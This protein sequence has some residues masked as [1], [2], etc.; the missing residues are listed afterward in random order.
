MLVRTFRQLLRGRP[1]SPPLPASAEDLTISKIDDGVWH[2]SPI[3]PEDVVE[4][5]FE[6]RGK[7]FL[8]VLEPGELPVF[9]QVLDGIKDSAAP[10]NLVAEF[11]RRLGRNPFVEVPPPWYRRFTATRPHRAMRPGP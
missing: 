10:I 6:N 4:L 8:L 2:F 5:E 1:K 11:E 7:R 3:D 9:D